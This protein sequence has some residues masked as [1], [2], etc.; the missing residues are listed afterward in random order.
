MTAAQRVEECGA[1]HHE[2][3]PATVASML[4]H[5]IQNGAYQKSFPQKKCTDLQYNLQRGR[6]LDTAS[7]LE[8]SFFP[9]GKTVQKLGKRA[10]RGA[11]T[12]QKAKFRQKQFPTNNTGNHTLVI[13]IPPLIKILYNENG[14]LML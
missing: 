4:Q 8:Y 13:V 11:E 10:P 14:E 2:S 7:P 3:A 6:V 9:I 1:H 5:R 12:A